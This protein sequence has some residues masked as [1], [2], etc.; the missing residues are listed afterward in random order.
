M[1][2]TA[3]LPHE[4]SSII[5]EYVGGYSVLCVLTCKRWKGFIPNTKHGCPA[6]FAACIAD[7]NKRIYQLIDSNK[8]VPYIKPQVVEGMLK[9]ISNHRTDVLI[10]FLIQVDQHWWIEPLVKKAVEYDERLVYKILIPK[11]NKS[12]MNSLIAYAM[13]VRN[14]DFVRY[15]VDYAEYQ[16]GKMIPLIHCAD[17]IES[18][19][20]R[21]WVI[22]TYIDTERYGKHIQYELHQCMINADRQKLQD[23]FNK[24][25]H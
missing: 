5:F 17:D 8:I 21:Q 20:S 24:M 22:D 23:M 1:D 16:L 7:N 9:A 13:S 10:S 3:I 14:W 6:L 11:H 19:E 25:I 18:E 4:L 15:Y 2:F 12:F